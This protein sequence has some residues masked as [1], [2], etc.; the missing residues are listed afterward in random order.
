MSKHSD[1]IYAGYSGDGHTTKNVSSTKHSFEDSL[2]QWKMSNDAIIKHNVAG[3]KKVKKSKAKKKTGG[4]DGAG[5]NPSAD[6]ED[7]ESFKHAA[8]FHYDFTESSDGGK[9]GGYHEEFERSSEGGVDTTE[10]S[11]SSF[12]IEAK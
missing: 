4:D 5:N 12:I 8:V 1:Q 11:L 3:E 2:N 6:D 7:S 10:Q 9:E